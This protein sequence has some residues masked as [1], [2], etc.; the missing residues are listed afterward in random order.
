MTH[1]TNDN[2]NTNNDNDHSTEWDD[3]LLA[4]QRLSEETGQP[5]DHITGALLG[6][7]EE[8]IW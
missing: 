8:A 5:F 6:G 4:A 3:M 7:I 2:T 1:N